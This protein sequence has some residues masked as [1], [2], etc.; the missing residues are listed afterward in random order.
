MAT[1]NG[2]PLST[3]GSDGDSDSDGSFQ[4]SVQSDDDVILSESRPGIIQPGGYYALAVV[5]LLNL[6]NYS[7]RFV[8]WNTS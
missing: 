1:P 4:G 8:L 7:D 6:L 2:I 5:T 3:L